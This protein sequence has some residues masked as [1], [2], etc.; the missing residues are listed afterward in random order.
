MHASIALVLMM[1]GGPIFPESEITTIPLTDDLS[2]PNLIQ[3][4]EW[5]ERVKNKPLPRVPTLDDRQQS[6]DYYGRQRFP[7]GP[8]GAT[9]PNQQMIPDAPTS[10]D[11]QQHPVGNMNMP[12]QPGGA[13][14]VGGAYPPL[15]PRIDP[16]ANGTGLPGLG[17]G[18]FASVPGVGTPIATPMPATPS[19]SNYINNVTPTSVSQY[20][21][22]YGLPN[23]PNNTMDPMAA[24]GGGSKP[25]SGYTPPNGYTPW[26]SLYTPT[27]NG[28]LNPYTQRVQ[29]QFDQLNFNAH[30]SEQINGVQTMQRAIY[31]GTPGV[32]TNTGGV[33]GL[34]NPSTFQN[35]MNY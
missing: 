5:Q 4:Q 26:Q 28:T 1:V 21:A 11:G 23:S 29:P 22:R 32:E 30:T 18:P 31:G 16:Y 14:Q 19:V 12:Y 3:D 27:N 20:T 6:N 25:F 13:S 2:T 15:A 7:Y 8:N 33:N 35:Y 34:V 17:R 9:R 24:A 10:A